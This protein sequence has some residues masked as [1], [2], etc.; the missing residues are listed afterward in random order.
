M[1]ALCI[2]SIYSYIG[3]GLLL[4]FIIIDYIDNNL[5]KQISYQLDSYLLLILC[6][7]WLPLLIIFILECLFCKNEE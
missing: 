1:V 6:M 2:L 3:I 4:F 5:S 7:L